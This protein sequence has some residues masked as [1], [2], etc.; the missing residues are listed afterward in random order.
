MVKK[1]LIFSLLLLTAMV[2]PAVAYDLPE[3]YTSI[4]INPG[5]R[6]DVLLGYLY[7]VRALDGVSQKTLINVVNTDPNYGMVAKLRF[8]EY[9]R[10]RECLDFHFPLSKGDVWSAEVYQCSNGRAY[11][12]SDD[13]NARDLKA[14]DGLWP[15]YHDLNVVDQTVPCSTAFPALDT[16]NP[17]GGAGV[18]FSTGDLEAG[19]TNV[20]RCLYGYYEIIGEERVAGTFLHGTGN[21]TAGPP[22]INDCVDQ[23]PIITP[24]GPGFTRGPGDSTACGRDPQNS[25]FAETWLVRV[26]DGTAQQYQDTAI[27]NFSTTPLGIAA[28]VI[29]TTR[30]NLRDDAQGQAG[31]YGYGGFEQLESVLS[32]RYVYAQYWNDSAFGAR[33]SVVFT[34]PTKWVHFNRTT[35]NWIDRPFVGPRETKQ[36]ANRTD[37]FLFVIRDRE[38]N[39]LTAPPSDVIFSPA[40]SGTIPYPKWPYEVNICG[41]FSSAKTFQDNNPAPFNGSMIDGAYIWRDNLMIG[42]YLEGGNLFKVG[43]VVYDL[44]PNNYAGGAYVPDPVS[45]STGLPPVDVNGDPVGEQ[46]TTAASAFNFWF[47]PA[48]AD[49][50]LGYRGLPVIGGVLNEV[51]WVGPPKQNFRTAIPW[52]SAVHWPWSAAAAP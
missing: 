32:K 25:L 22:A 31:N 1:T 21:C 48:S 28:S 37:P 30:P 16:V 9:K 34:F 45:G 7:D 23:I 20:A 36:D 26:E 8:R 27:S 13:W 46:G 50:I 11:L 2:G 51:T 35:F 39:L 33:T 19:V 40:G 17:H 38:E 41:I 42:S 18:P 44:S 5:L 12:Y 29:G 15:L 14:A 4:Q 3:L 49:N 24:C 6:G 52:A 10:S 47:Q 43:W